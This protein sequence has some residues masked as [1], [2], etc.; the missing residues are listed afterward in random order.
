MLPWS[1]LGLILFLVF[2]NDLD[3][4]MTK[5][6]VLKKFADGTKMGQTVGNMEEKKLQMTIANLIEWASAWAIAF[7]VAKCEIMHFQHKNPG[8]AYTMN[9]QP[10]KGGERH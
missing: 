7:K 6:E 5:I 10:E 8:C 2:I 3:D 1:V 4:V 9:G